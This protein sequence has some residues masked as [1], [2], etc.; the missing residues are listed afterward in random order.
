VVRMAMGDEP[1]LDVLLQLES[2]MVAGNTYRHRHSAFTWS[3][4]FRG[5]KPS[6]SSSTR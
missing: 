1:A 6:F 4:T 2:G 5:V 3:Y